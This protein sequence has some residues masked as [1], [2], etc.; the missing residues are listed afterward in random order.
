MT[1]CVCTERDAVQKCGTEHAL[2]QF[3]KLPSTVRREKWGE[4]KK[5]GENHQKSVCNTVTVSQNTPSKNSIV[6]KQ[7]LLTDFKFDST[8]KTNRIRRQH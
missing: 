8:S 2:T 7:T 3:L 1:I 4:I 6:R 5:A